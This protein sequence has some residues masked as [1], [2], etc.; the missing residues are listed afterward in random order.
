MW[1]HFNQ[2]EVLSCHTYMPSESIQFSTHLKE[3]TLENPDNKALKG[4]PRLRIGI[5]WTVANT[6]LGDNFLAVTTNF[7]LRIMCF[8]QSVTYRFRFRG[9]GSRG[10]GISNLHILVWH[11]YPSLVK[12]RS[13]RP[14]SNRVQQSSRSGAEGAREPKATLEI[15]QY[16]IHQK[17]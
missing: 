11:H 3:Q 17:S 5:H 14:H 13:Q 8:E 6:S 2:A 1:H 7:E 4:P 12:L 10:G 16:R 15:H 9:W